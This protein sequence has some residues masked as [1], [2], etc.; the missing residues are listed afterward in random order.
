MKSLTKRLAAT[1]ITTALS[2]TAATAQMSFTTYADPSNPNYI[3]IPG[4]MDRVKERTNGEI[5]WEVYFGGSLIPPKDALT[6]IGTGVAQGGQHVATYSPSVNPLTAALADLAFKV[7][8]P[9]VVAFA[10]TDYMLTD[11][12]GKG[13]WL[14]N[15][16]VALHGF[17]TTAYRFMCK[18]K[19][20]DSLEDLKGKKV[21]TAGAPWVRFVRSIGAV[22]VSI[23]VSE[24]YTAMERGLIDCALSDVSH[25]IAGANLGD[26]LGSIAMIDTGPF[27]P[28][29]AIVI[30]KDTWNSFTPEQR[31]I[32]LEELPQTIVGTQL[33][34]YEKLAIDGLAAAKGKGI[35]INEPSA[36]LVA[37]YDAFLTTIDA[38]VIAA[39]Q[40]AGV[41]SIEQ[42]V[43]DFN[44]MLQKW[45]GLLEGVDRT[46]EAALI[47][48]VKAEIIDKVDPETLAQR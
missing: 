6:G 27:F 24:M 29:S 45:D 31:K 40:A 38:D 41:T 47:A 18:D 23:P 20:V 42:E 37:A 14:D 9:L 17:S 43:S 16:T 3:E 26:L 21:R 35:Q 13:E 22:D 36:D 19:D 48:L 46:D 33:A 11:P 8:D 30:N 15:N 12:E 32:M 28:G 2:A 25:I 7:P 4:W 1:A 5:E 10:S 44:A 34:G 39:G